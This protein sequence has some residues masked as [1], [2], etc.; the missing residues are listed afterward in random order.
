MKPVLFVT[1]YVPP[2]KQ[3]AFAMLAEREEVEFAVFGGKTHHGGIEGNSSGERGND[4]N[5][6]VRTVT[7]RDV[8]S[9]AKS[10]S[11]RAV[12]AGISGRTALLA[13]YL[14][15]RRARIPFVLWATLWAHPKTLAHAFSYLPLRHIYRNADAV[16]T[17]GAHVSRY[18]ENKGAKNVFIA[19]QS[20]DNDFWRAEIAPSERRSDSFQALY[21]GRFEKEKGI[22]VLLEGWRLSALAEA[23]SQLV[24]VGNGPDPIVPGVSVTGQLN[25]EN[26]RNFYASSDVLVLPSI[27]TRDFREPWGLVINEAM[28]RQLPII[29]STSV[30]AVAGGLAVDGRNAVVFES[31]NP[32]S[33]ATKLKQ[34]AADPER[35]SKLGEQG[36]RDVLAY[37]EIEW[38]SGFSS[39]LASIGTSRGE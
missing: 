35:R 29:A 10:G 12:I 1:N 2:A 3:K 20:V 18:V 39:A 13:A 21:V 17:Y 37:T 24:L 19:P 32:T 4:T 11:Y 28:N 38:S 25:L 33:L 31:G 15:A 7:Q 30:G 8:Y 36:S 22:D 6:I 14:G 9:L 26:L 27:R 5:F 16:V 34:L 23:G